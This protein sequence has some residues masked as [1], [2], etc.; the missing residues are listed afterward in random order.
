LARDDEAALEFPLSDSIYGFHAQQSCEK[1]LK[2]LVSSLGLAYP[3][4][5]SLEQLADLLIAA[6]ETLPSLPCDLLDLEPFAVEFRY[7]VGAVIADAEK[8]VIQES[9][10]ALRKHVIARILEIEATP[11][12]KS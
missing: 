4:T 2:A 5:H 8:A 3:K 9:V 12:H 1:L 7:D 6:N 11:P 10:A